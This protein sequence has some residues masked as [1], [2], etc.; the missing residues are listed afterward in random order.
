MDTSWMWVV[1]AIAILMSLVVLIVVV[2]KKGDVFDSIFCGFIFI[3][4]LFISFSKLPLISDRLKVLEATVSSHSFNEV[5]SFSR[6]TNGLYHVLDVRRGY[7]GDWL[8]I[9]QPTTITKI[10]SVNRVVEA[11]D[12]P[13]SFYLVSI[14]NPV[15]FLGSTNYSGFAEIGV[16]NGTSFIRDYH[17]LKYARELK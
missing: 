7:M 11:V 8:A 13:E 2:L 5:K 6:M 17:P 4:T 9:I 12:I 3:A 16:E 10:D 15:S 1:S 14:P